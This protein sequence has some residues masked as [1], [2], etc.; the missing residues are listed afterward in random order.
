MKRLQDVSPVVRIPTQE[1]VVAVP[2]PPVEEVISTPVL[3]TTSEPVQETKPTINDLLA[4]RPDATLATKFEL[5]PIADLKAI[6]NL[7]DKLVFVKDL[8]NGYS[9][10]YQEAIDTLNKLGSLEEA[11]SYLD[12]NYAKAND[13]AAHEATTAR[14][15][16]L[17]TRRYT[18]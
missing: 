11:K 14:F 9:L 4:D 12:E 18:K 7:N 13:W 10:A 1:P 5:E 16:E 6:I 3:E 15:Y 17:V 8:F 2:T